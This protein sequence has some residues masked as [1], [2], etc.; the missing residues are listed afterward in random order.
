MLQRFRRRTI[1]AVRAFDMKK[2]EERL[3]S[4]P[5]QP[6]LSRAQLDAFEQRRKALLE[7]VAQMEAEHGEV[8]WA[9]E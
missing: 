9:W 3:R 7:W 6:V 4:E 5:V 2:F 8:I 1:A